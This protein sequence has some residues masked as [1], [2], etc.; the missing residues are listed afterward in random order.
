VVKQ[1]GS[2]TAVKETFGR[3]TEKSDHLPE[4][5]LVIIIIAFSNINWVEQRLSF[6]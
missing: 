2:P 6:K 5:R 1:G 3:W 4:M